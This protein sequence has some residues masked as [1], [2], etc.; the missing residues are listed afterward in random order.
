MSRCSDHVMPVL[1]EKEGLSTGGLFFCRIVA[2]VK[3]DGCSLSTKNGMSG[4]EAF[5]K[6]TK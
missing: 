5:D 6:R 2:A 3:R 1:R 4:E